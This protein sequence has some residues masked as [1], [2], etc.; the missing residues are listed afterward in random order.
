MQLLEVILLPK[1][2]LKREKQESSH[3]ARWVKDPVLSLQ[4][5]RLLLWFRFVPWTRT[6]T[7]HKHGQ[8]KGRGRA[9]VG[10]KQEF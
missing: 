8:K 3:V 4:W 5:L 7:H 6:S 2:A 9:E 1:E 10:E